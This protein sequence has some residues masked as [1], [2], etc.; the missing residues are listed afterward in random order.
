M[1]NWAASIWRAIGWPFRS[2][3]QGL[4]WAL[5]L[6]SDQ[7]RALM[8]W[9]MLTGIAVIGSW[10]VGLTL[11][12]DHAVHAKVS[13]SAFFSILTEQIRYNSVLQALM[14]F[15]IVSIAIQAGTFKAKVG[16]LIDIDATMKQA[17]D[18]APNIVA[19]TTDHP[20]VIP[21]AEPGPE[22]SPVPPAPYQDDP[23]P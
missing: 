19:A 13:E 5:N 22:I 10:N 20:P 16:D 2:V 4:I 1:K 9:A 17:I 12:A 15:G 21:A 8:C 18:D 11:L 6:S 3:G 14:I 23:R 7:I